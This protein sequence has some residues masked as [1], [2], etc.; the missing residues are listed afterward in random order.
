MKDGL[1]FYKERIF[2]VLETR[3]KEQILK[4]FHDIPMAG[5]PRFYK[6]YKWVRKR[7]SWKG[8]K[9]DITKY[10]RECKVCQQKKKRAHIPCWSATTI[11]HSC[12]KVGEY[13]NGFHHGASQG[14]KEGLY[15]CGS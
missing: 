5:H 13:L 12:S 8:M 7:F 2:L 11:A 14:A 10:V 15:L 6:T 9:D 1:I 4:T 3:M